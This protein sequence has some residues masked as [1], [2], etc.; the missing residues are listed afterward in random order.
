MTQDDDDLAR[1]T[2]MMMMMATRLMYITQFAIPFT[3]LRD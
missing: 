3:V 2:L 1:S